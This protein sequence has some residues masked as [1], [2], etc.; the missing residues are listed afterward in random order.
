WNQ[1][2]KLA[3]SDALPEAGSFRPW[4]C[5]VPT[6]SPAPPRARLAPATRSS[7]AR[8]R[9]GHAARIRRATVARVRAR[10][11]EMR[12]AR[13]CPPRSSRDRLRPKSSPA[14]SPSEI[15]H[16]E[17]ELK[18]STS[19]RDRSKSTVLRD[20]V[21][22]SLRGRRVAF[23]FEF[24]CFAMSPAAWPV[25]FLR[26]E[27]PHAPTSSCPRGARTFRRASPYF[28]PR[29]TRTRVGGANHLDPL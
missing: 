23:S 16:R 22:D 15:G 1:P 24:T 7:S 29:R 5:Q 11:C 18:P 27:L 21:L 4:T 6:L 25:R 13:I 12:I 2:S 3:V 20:S 17:R 9:V 14:P 28:A 8:L 10:P 19:S 26:T